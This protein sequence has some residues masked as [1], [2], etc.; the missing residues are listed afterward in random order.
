MLRPAP[1]APVELLVREFEL[2]CGA[3]KLKTQRS[4]RVDPVSNHLWRVFTIKT[5]GRCQSATWF[6][7]NCNEAGLGQ[8][9]GQ[10]EMPRT[11]NWP[12]TLEPDHVDQQVRP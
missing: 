4:I 6:L 11:W 8:R 1:S 3:G 9:L 7:S 5:G 12:Q 10:A 2:S